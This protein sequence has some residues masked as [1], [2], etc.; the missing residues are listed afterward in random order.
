MKASQLIEQLEQ[1]IEHLGDHDVV[2]VDSHANTC[3][4]QDVQLMHYAHPTIIINTN[5]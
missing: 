1:A 3:D 4:V 2:V 5:P